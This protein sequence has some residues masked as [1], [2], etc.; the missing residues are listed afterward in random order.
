MPAPRPITPTGARRILLRAARLEQPRFGRGR[1]GAKR[2]LEAMGEIQLDPIDR[3]GP[4]ADLVL[5]ARVDGVRRGI[6]G[7]LGDTF[8]HFA[9]E[10]CLLP[11]RRFPAWR[12]RLTEA[13]WWRLNSRL[14]RLDSSV[15]EA[16]FTMVSERGPLT[17][18][19]LGDLGR[20]EAIDWSGWKG[21]P[22]AGTMALEVL[23][24]RC[25]IV[26]TGRSANGHRVFDLPE[27]ALGPH[28]TATAPDFFRDGLQHRL[29][30]AG[31]LRTAGGPQWSALSPMRGGPLI[32]T[33]L[34][35]GALVEVCLP[36]TRRRWFCLPEALE[37][38]DEPLDLDDRVRVLGPLDPLL[39]DR[40][41]VHLVFGFDYVW[42][43]YKPAAQRRWGYYVCPLLWRGQLVGRLEAHRGRAGEA[44]L[45][46]DHLWWE[47]DSPR[48]PAA[49]VR[50]ML[51]RLARFQ[52][53]WPAATPTARQE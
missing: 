4:N 13:P 48:P 40:P 19:D 9:K 12:Q 51:A 21:T 31:L 24:T 23:W 53:R 43:V 16:V 20:V 47:A 2:C 36:G 25:Q 50:A 41:L 52:E 22:K 37:T 14:E 11:A 1:A 30:V 44:P 5:Q 15:L 3:I 6:A 35:S 18:H 34:A 28:A 8:E 17:S 32:N 46:V 38:I 10:R 45:V 42:E 26:V 33:A 29:R 27:R 49:R 39:W 7:A